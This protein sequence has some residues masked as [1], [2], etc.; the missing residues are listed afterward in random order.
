MTD[1]KCIYVISPAVHYCQESGEF[2]DC[3]ECPIYK[4]RMRTK[5]DK[6]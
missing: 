3:H 5:K 1:R 4:E 2:P 6:E